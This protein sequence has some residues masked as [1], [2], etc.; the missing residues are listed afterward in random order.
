MRKISFV[1]I[2]SALIASCITI[3]EH[4]KITGDLN[5]QL[6][7]K[8]SQLDS[9]KNQLEKSRKRLSQ[10]GDLGITDKAAANEEVRAVSF[11]DDKYWKPFNNPERYKN[12]LTLGLGYIWVEDTAGNFT[13]TGII[14]L[15]QYKAEPTIIDEG[16]VIFKYYVN[17]KF[18]TKVSAVSAVTAGLNNEEFAKLNYQ[19][20]GTSRLKIL[21][22]SLPSIAKKYAASKY[23]STVKAVYL[24]TGFHIRKISLQTYKKM[25]GDMTVTVPVANVNG[26]L[27]NEQQ[28]ELNNWQVDGRL[29]DL[30]L[31][32]P[33]KELERES[34]LAIN[35]TPFDFL[36]SIF[37]NQIPDSTLIAIA[38]D[39]S[40]MTNEN[41][42]KLKSML[43]GKNIP[44]SDADKLNKIGEKLKRN[45]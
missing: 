20:I 38:N 12:F 11:K 8:Q 7:T 40:L 43:G 16:D 28:T 22:D 35:Q 24:S 45:D 13:E 42:E 6:S 15:E 25:D 31:F 39:P 9:T 10:V 14:P 27:Y 23:N 34:A 2:T 5:N 32:L 30:G 3:K 37:G 17:N 33:N 44:K 18:N 41:L 21:Q 36:K 26:S 29:I 1:I 4:E 19:I